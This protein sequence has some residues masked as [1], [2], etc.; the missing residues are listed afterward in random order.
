MIGSQVNE[1]HTVSYTN[2]GDVVFCETCVDEPLFDV[3]RL[4]AITPAYVNEN[5]SGR[6]GGDGLF[7][8]RRRWRLGLDR[9]AVRFGVGVRR[10]CGSQD[11]SIVVVLYRWLP[12]CIRGVRSTATNARSRRW[13][14]LTRSEGERRVR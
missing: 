12:L 4:N 14:K 9:V 3:V 8:S 7:T 1:G 5:V 2:A 10:I 6:I 11:G 13:R